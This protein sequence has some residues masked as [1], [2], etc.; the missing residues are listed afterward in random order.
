MC[1]ALV[2]GAPWDGEVG[3]CVRTACVREAQGCA[4]QRRG[5]CDGVPSIHMSMCSDCHTN[6]SLALRSECRLDPGSSP[7]GV[8]T[9]SPSLQSVTTMK[10]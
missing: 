6:D 10:M 4:S 5:Q 8:T 3:G 7:G 2:C 1:E 9:L